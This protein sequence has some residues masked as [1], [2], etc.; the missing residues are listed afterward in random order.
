MAGVPG[1]AP[2]TIAPVSGSMVDGGAT[3]AAAAAAACA[4][5]A[6]AAVAGSLPSSA[7]SFSLCVSSMGGSPASST[8]C[9]VQASSNSPHPVSVSSKGWAVERADGVVEGRVQVE[10]H[11]CYDSRQVLA[12]GAAHVE[13]P[14]VGLRVGGL[15]EERVGVRERAKR[16]RGRDLVERSRVFACALTFFP[17]ENAHVPMMM[18]NTN[19]TPRTRVW[20]SCE[21]GGS[22]RGRRAASETGHAGA[23]PFL[24]SSLLPRPRTSPARRRRPSWRE[25]LRRKRGCVWRNAGAGWRDEGKSKDKTLVRSRLSTYTHSANCVLQ[26]ATRRSASLFLAHTLSPSPSGSETT[27]HAYGAAKRKAPETRHALQARLPLSMMPTQTRPLHLGSVADLPRTYSAILLDQFGCLH[28]GRDALPGAVEAV[29]ALASTGARVLI[30]S[31]S[32]RRASGA[33]AK[34]E[35]LGFDP[36][37]STR[38]PDVGRSRARSPGGA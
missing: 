36:A 21:M 24:F 3:P 28:D 23:D 15:R 37:C 2:A 13:R 18:G 34:L 7:Y 27:G 16:S 11:F 31:N 38:R 6:A 19:S 33:V 1:A 5:A 30:L 26:H 14:P 32:S 17:S 8:Q 29:K 9:S 22:V 20:P 25:R 10:F 4:W 12:A 35:K